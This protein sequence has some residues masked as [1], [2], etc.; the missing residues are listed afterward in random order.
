MHPRLGRQR[1]PEL[2]LGLVKRAPNP[3]AGKSWQLLCLTSS[4][5]SVLNRIKLATAI[6]Q[7]SLSPVEDASNAH[8]AGKHA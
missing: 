8:R 4:T 3:L 1:S 7:N 2:A 5:L 6:P